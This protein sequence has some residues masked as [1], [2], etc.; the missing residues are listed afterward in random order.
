M[1][2]WA[3]TNKSFKLLSGFLAKGHVPRVSR[4][5][6]ND[7]DTIPGPVHR[8]PGIYLRAEENPGKPQLGD[9]LMK[10]VRTVISNGVPYFKEKSVGSHISRTEKERKEGRF[11]QLL[12]LVSINRRG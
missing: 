11:K 2:R 3:A 4:L 1:E 5:S 8:S 9:R 7:S 10:T 6:A 12:Q